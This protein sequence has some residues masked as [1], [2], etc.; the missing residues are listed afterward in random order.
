MFYLAGRVALSITATSKKN[1]S[2]HIEQDALWMKGMARI[3]DG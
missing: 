2:S 1:T 3:R